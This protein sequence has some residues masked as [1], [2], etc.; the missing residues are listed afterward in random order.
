MQLFYLPE[1]AE[2]GRQL[3]EEESMHCVR[4]LRMKEGDEIS[5]VDGQGGFYTAAIVK[6]DPKKC[7]FEIMQS[8]QEFG[9]RDYSIHMAIAPTKNA[10]RLEWFVEKAVELGVDQ[11]SL[12][13]T[14]HSERKHTNTERLKKIAISAMKQS[15]KAYLPVIHEVQPLKEFVA[16]TM[17]S[18][19][20][21]AH[22][23]AGEK[24][25]LKDAL[26]PGGDYCV[27]IGPEGDFSPAEI[28]FA[29]K[30]NFIPVTLGESRLRTETAGIAACHILN[31][32]NE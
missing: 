19:K 13:R 9:K 1:I 30:S 16:H 15:V 4:V 17:E 5:I 21:V 3:S 26:R 18:Q 23:E 6:A 12:I 2:G 8:N 27:M 20:F 7:L 14:E 24:K 31:L 10:D 11:I 25:H 28:G 32:I 29:L 22:L